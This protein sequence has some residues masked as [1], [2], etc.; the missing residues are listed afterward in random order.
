MIKLRNLGW[1]DDP[2]FSGLALNGITKVLMRGR[3]REVTYMEEEKA[4]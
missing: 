1:G 4:M 3:L 2:G